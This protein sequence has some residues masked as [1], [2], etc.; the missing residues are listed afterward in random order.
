MPKSLFIGALSGISLGFMQAHE[1]GDHADAA[2][3]LAGAFEIDRQLAANQVERRAI[4]TDDQISDRLRTERLAELGQGELNW[5]DGQRERLAVW[6]M[7]AAELEWALVKRGV[8]ADASA[9]IR[10]VEIR[11]RFA[12][13]DDMKRLGLLRQAI[14]RR[15]EG[16]LVFLQAILAAN[17]LFSDIPAGIRERI[18]KIILEL[19]EPETFRQFQRLVLQL[20]GFEEVVD[21]AS[22][23]VKSDANLTPSQ[24]LERE[25]DEAARRRM[26]AARS[27]V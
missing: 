26:A 10:A 9:T 20:D 27:R 24:R 25:H 8:P 5:L 1:S 15:S 13:L 12:A 22:R 18:G 4:V 7:H 21:V 16:D 17:D 19:S 14:D 6:R 23:Y 2:A 3:A 11:G